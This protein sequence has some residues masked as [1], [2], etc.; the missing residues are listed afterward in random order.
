MV[1]IVALCKR[2]A[3]HGGSSDVAALAYEKVTGLQGEA[4]LVGLAEVRLV[5]IG[6]V[7]IAQKKFFVRRNGRWLSPTRFACDTF[8]PLLNGKQ[9]IESMRPV[10]GEFAKFR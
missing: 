2:P 9:G 5:E 10:N 4:Y 6:Q 8:L 1:L 7:E 3:P